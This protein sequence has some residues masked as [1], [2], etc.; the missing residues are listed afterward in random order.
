VGVT[1]VFLGI[2][3]LWL[4]SDS[5]VWV[6]DPDDQIEKARIANSVAAQDLVRLPWGT[7]AVYIQLEG[8]LEVICRDGTI[9]NGGYVNSYFGGTFAVSEDCT[10]ELA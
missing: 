4:L 8:G 10:I 5:F 3:I 1:T 7:H 9:A 2:P 6:V